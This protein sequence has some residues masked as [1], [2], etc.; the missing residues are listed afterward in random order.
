MRPRLTAVWAA[1]CCV[2][3]ALAQAGPRSVDHYLTIPAGSTCV[4]QELPVASQGWTLDRIVM[5]NAGA[6]TAAVSVA[7]ADLGVYTAVDAFALSAG[8][9]ESRRPPGIA[10]PQ[11][12]YTYVVTGDVALVKEVIA[13]NYAPVAV[14]DLRFIAA[15]ATNATDVVIYY[16]IY[17][18]SAAN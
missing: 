3:A 18:S 12:G 8:G 4:T 5:Y 6:V 11:A 14:R 2:A 7:A 16:R 10:V 17:G 9:G 1:L 15:K 13:T